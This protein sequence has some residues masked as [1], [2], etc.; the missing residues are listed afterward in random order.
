MFVNIDAPQFRDFLDRSM[1]PDS[2]SIAA[3]SAR[4]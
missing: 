2:M 4:A 3:L 1:A